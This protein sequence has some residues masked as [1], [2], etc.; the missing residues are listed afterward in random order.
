M[1]V[2]GHNEL[3]TQVFGECLFNTIVSANENNKS[4]MESHKMMKNSA[5]NK[6]T[7]NYFSFHE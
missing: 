5:Y 1:A 7:D 3:I 6:N 2:L 4:L